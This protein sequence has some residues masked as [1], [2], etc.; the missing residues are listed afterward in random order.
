MIGCNRCKFLDLFYGQTG[1]LDYG[2]V[3]I[4]GM[5][6]NLD[7]VFYITACF[8]VAVLDYD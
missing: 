1:V 7:P 6:Q 3:F 2:Y 5:N 8:R 4:V